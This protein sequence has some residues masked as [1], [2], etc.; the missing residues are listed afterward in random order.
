MLELRSVEKEFGDGSA[1][2]KVVDGV[3]LS[4]EGGEIVW[5][6]GKSGSGK[7]TL[8]RIAGLLSKPDSG[9][10]IFGGTPVNWSKPMDALRRSEVGIIFQH[11]NLFP[12]M[13]AV[14]NLAVAGSTLT[15][16]EIRVLL[17]N[18]DLESI[19]D[20]KAKVFS[21]GE[22]QRVA[23]CRSLAHDPSFLLAD[24]PTAGLDSENVAR[25]H[26][27]L[28]SS[29]SASRGVLV[30]SHDPATES[31]ADRVVTIEEGRIV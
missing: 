2:V 14:Q 31:L 3:S 5:L 15:E 1:R 21:G 26:A 11:S 12:E 9:E 23:L 24:E 7:S 17:Q 19:A 25:V 10:V 16:D 13:T 20:R 6:R 28:R 27:Q 22:A 4:V 8:I 30:A 18:F 29:A